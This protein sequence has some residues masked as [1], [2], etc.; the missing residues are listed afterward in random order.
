M[1]MRENKILYSFIISLS[2]VI[3][4]LSQ[5]E[6]FSLTLF[7]QCCIW[8][9]NGQQLVHAADYGSLSLLSSAHTT[10]GENWARNHSLEAK[11]FPFH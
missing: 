6:V 11:R 10:T 3:N 9:S 2:N 8:I 5:P 1:E 4:A 7:C